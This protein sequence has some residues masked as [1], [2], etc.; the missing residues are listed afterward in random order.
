MKV[1]VFD[2]W[3][4]VGGRRVAVWRRAWRRRAAPKTGTLS[5]WT[6]AELAAIAAA[7]GRRG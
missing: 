4:S 1:I 3:L 6:P 5:P 7:I 2:R